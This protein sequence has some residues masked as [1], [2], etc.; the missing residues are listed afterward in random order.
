MKLDLTF[1]TVT[2]DALLLSILI[3]AHEG[4]DHATAEVAVAY[5]RAEMDDVFLIKFSCR[6][7][8]I[9]IGMKP[10]YEDFVIY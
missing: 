5:R 1:P 10:E 4:R 9:Q 2:S 7:V 6:F 3:D 8:Y